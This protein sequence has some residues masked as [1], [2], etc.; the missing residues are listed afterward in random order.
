VFHADK[1]E[2]PTKKVPKRHLFEMRLGRVAQ[3]PE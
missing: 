2:N 3:R 1:A